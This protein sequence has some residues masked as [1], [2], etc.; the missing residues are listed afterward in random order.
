MRA[1]NAFTIFELLA[2]ITIITVLLTILLPALHHA[3]EVARRA[4]CASN[5]KNIGVALRLYAVDHRS[6][7]PAAELGYAAN[8]NGNGRGGNARWQV[9]GNPQNLWAGGCVAKG[10][11][12]WERPV[13]PYV[14][15]SGYR[16]FRCPT[17]NG[18]P[19][20]WNAS[21]FCD[22]SFYNATGTS[23]EFNTGPWALV[24]VLFDG[25]PYRL[26]AT[27]TGGCWGAKV[28][29]FRNA[30]LQV[31]AAEWSAICWGSHEEAS[32]PW[33]EGLQ[34]YLPGHDQK[35]PLNPLMNIVFVDGHV[36]MLTLQRYPD[37][38]KNAQYE[39]TQDY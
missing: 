11:D 31:L 27:V 2:V 1:R 35:D 19:D 5:L 16:V 15:Y 4:V 24:G 22:D 21:G 38:Y 17:E 18:P 23:Y 20:G 7:F 33:V 9:M 13:N 26:A 3:K 30:S 10:T 6:T 8:S 29:S 25:T 36:K 37:H 39:M 14:N 34:S 28:H 12:T 32:P